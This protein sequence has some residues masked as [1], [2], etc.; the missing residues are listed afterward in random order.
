MNTTWKREDLAWAAGFFEGEGCV[1]AAQ[2]KQNKSLWEGRT[3]FDV[4]Q[5]DR[6]MLDRFQRIFGCGKVYGP[7]SKPNRLPYYR[8]FVVNFEQVQMLVILLWPWL[9]QRRRAQATLA[10]KTC[11]TA[12]RARRIPGPKKS[13]SQSV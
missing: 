8:F 6:E 7:Y 11:A 12:R 4:S 10:L 3:Y 2:D 1:R 13:E 9:S 5:S